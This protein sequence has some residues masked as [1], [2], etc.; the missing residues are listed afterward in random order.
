[1]RDNLA[2]LG[3]SALAAA[4]DA[5]IPADWW[6][7]R[8]FDR[9]LLDAPCSGTGVIRRHP[10]I[11]LLRRESD[12]AALL[13]TQAEL[14][15]ALWPLLA[16]GGRLVYATCSVLADENDGQVAAFLERR[17]DACALDL[18]PDWFGRDQRHGRQNLAGEGGFDGFYYAVLAHRA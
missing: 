8:A 14:L 11:R 12:L 17:R 5:A 16:P 6:D 7:G 15:D 4:G 13:K 10:D 3:L 18:V 1:V 9:I 2:R